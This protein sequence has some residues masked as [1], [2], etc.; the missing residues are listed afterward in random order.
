MRLLP[1]GRC[2]TRPLIRCGLRITDALRLPADCLVTDTDGAPYLRYDNH[3]MKRQAPV[4]FDEELQA[5]ISAERARNS[6][7]PTW[8]FQR[9]TKN[10]DGRL[11]THA[12][13]HRGA[14][15]GWLARCATRTPAGPAH[16]APVAPHPRDAPDQP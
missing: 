8:L 2:Q 14:L 4:P 6:S 1:A 13:T 12:S 7:S 3:K 10:P 5:L 15:Y 9:L 11:P 16:P